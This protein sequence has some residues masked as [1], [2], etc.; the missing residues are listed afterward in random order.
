MGMEDFHATMCKNLGYFV[1]T[2][3]ISGLLGLSESYIDNMMVLSKVK[4]KK[5]VFEGCPTCPIVGF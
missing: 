1:H 4:K 2:G 3:K 5:N